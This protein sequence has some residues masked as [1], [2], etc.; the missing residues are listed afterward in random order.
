MICGISLLTSLRGMPVAMA[1]PLPPAI[2]KNVLLLI[3][4]MMSRDLGALV[5]VSF[6]ERFG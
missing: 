2:H 4:D 1:A 6:F 3:F 5:S